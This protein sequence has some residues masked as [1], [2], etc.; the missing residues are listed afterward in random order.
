MRTTIISLSLI[1]SALLILDSMNAGYAM[2]MFV[3]AGQIP[4]T[5][6]VIDATSMLFVLVLAVGIVAGRLTGR[7]ILLVDVFNRKNTLGPQ[8]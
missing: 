2:M 4:G 8:L 5:T 7:L 3:I 1:L 6:T